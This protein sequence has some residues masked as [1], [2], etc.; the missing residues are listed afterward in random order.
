[1]LPQLMPYGAHQAGGRPGVPRI[2]QREITKTVTRDVIIQVKFAG[3][4]L[5]DL[6]QRAGKYPP[7]PGASPILGLEVSGQIM[8]RG[9]EVTE[10]DIGD[11]GCGLTPGGGY[12]EDCF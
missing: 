6:L 1:M 4:N 8:A 9:A 3:V 12:A 2:E 10:G 7:P 5:P 11:A